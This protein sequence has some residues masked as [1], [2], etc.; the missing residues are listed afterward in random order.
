VPQLELNATSSD[1]H[2]QSIFSTTLF[3]WSP[4]EGESVVSSYVWV[5][6]V[7]SVGLTIATM[8][9]WYVTTIRDKKREKERKGIRELKDM[10]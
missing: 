2:P 7:L 6:V 4:G 9:I 5:L 10:A 3:N 8:L 1:S